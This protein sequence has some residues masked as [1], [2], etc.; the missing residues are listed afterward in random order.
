MKEFYGDKQ[1]QKLLEAW[2]LL[3]MKIKFH[4]KLFLEISRKN[5]Q[6]ILKGISSSMEKRP[7]IFLEHV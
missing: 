4:A 1:F 3:I 2:I 6:T 5:L 7:L